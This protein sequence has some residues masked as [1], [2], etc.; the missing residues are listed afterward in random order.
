MFLLRINF[1][2]IGPGDNTKVMRF[3]SNRL[4]VTTFP[5]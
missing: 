4:F 3:V 1:A 5:K 2:Q